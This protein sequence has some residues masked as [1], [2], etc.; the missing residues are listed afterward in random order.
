M[1]ERSADRLPAGSQ[2]APSRV[3]AAGGGVRQP[4]SR[5]GPARPVPVR[6]DQGLRPGDRAVRALCQ[7]RR[8]ARHRPRRGDPA[9]GARLRQRRDAR[10]RGALGRAVPRGDQGGRP[11]L[12]GGLQ[13][14]SRP[15]RARRASHAVRR[16]RRRDGP[17]H[18]RPGDRGDRAA[19]MVGDAARHAGAVDRSRGVDRQDSDPRGDRPFRPHRRGPGA[20]P[21]GIPGLSRPRP[22]AACLGQDL[23]RRATVE[24]RPPL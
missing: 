13:G 2:P 14:L 4:F 12:G 24:D 18:V 5:H 17:R 21:A 11:V 3:P 16:R 15:G 22:R 8:A 1:S 9:D 20:R 19:W 23:L 7:P 10:C 6:R